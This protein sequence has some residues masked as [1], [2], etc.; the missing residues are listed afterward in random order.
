V[1]VT[2]P[3][4]KVGNAVGA[5]V[6]AG[7]IQAITGLPLQFNANDELG[8]QSVTY[9]AGRTAKPDLVSVTKST[10]VFNHT[11]VAYTFDSA[12]PALPSSTSGLL[13]SEPPDVSIPSE[14]RST[15]A[16]PQAPVPGPASLCRSSVTP[17][18]GDDAYGGRVPVN[19]DGPQS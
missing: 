9:V 11:W 4:G 8:L 14:H 16:G 18:P 1:D 5:S 13:R 17:P 10:D 7:A 19:P 3:L 2:F 6:A 12:L 15:L